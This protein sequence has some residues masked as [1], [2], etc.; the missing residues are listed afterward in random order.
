MITGLL[1]KALHVKR[2]QTWGQKRIAA[3][4]C[5]RCGKTRGPTA[6]Q[7]Y[8]RVCADRMSAYNKVWGVGRIRTRQRPPA[9]LTPGYSFGRFLADQQ[10]RVQARLAGGMERILVA[11]N[12]QMD[13][14]DYLRLL[15]VES[16]GQTQGFQR[17]GHH[18]GAP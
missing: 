18:T 7:T 6:T 3:G 12:V 2:V 14:R 17:P 9:P 8:C 5:R 4:R 13:R 1:A 11:R 15:T 16:R 10:A